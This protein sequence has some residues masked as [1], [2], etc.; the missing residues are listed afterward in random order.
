MN[1]NANTGQ[2]RV[3]KQ[4]WDKNEDIIYTRWPHSVIAIAAAGTA[5][6]SECHMTMQ[7]IYTPPKATEI[8]R[9]ALNEMGI[10]HELE[11]PNMARN[12]KIHNMMTYHPS[13][14]TA[15]LSLGDS[16][17]IM[18]QET[19]QPEGDFLIVT[20]MSLVN[21]RNDGHV[22]LIPAKELLENYD[23]E[24]RQFINTDSSKLFKGIS[25]KSTHIFDYFVPTKIINTPN[26]FIIDFFNKNNKIHTPYKLLEQ[27]AQFEVNSN[28]K[29][30][31][32][33]LNQF[34]EAQEKEKDT[35]FTT[36]RPSGPSMR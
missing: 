9:E 2:V 21:K 27:Q 33:A 3:Y 36:Q 10:S 12:N 25:Q 31:L 20:G 16:Y 15:T 29:I 34:I 26:A 5:I 17:Q 24:R 32:F 4:Y 11:A 22:I 23:Q 13:F 35:A 19:R 30:Q 1:A 8:I 14:L 6:G 28:Q 7:S 18:N